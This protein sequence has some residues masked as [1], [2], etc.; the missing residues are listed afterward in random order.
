MIVISVVGVVVVV[1]YHLMLLL[2][3]L[4]SHD[5]LVKSEKIG[6]ACECLHM[7]LQKSKQITNKKNRIEK[8]YNVL[9]ELR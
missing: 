6:T 5:L 7:I 1:F 4:S 9:S 3:V 2:F 8:E